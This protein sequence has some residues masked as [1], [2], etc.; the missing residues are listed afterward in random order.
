[1]RLTSDW[2]SSCTECL[3]DAAADLV[4]VAFL[5]T[6][7]VVDFVA[8]LAVAPVVVFVD[9]L[10][11]VSVLVASAGAGV[12]AGDVALDARTVFSARATFVAGLALDKM[13]SKGFEAIV[14]RDRVTI[15]V[16][17]AWDEITSRASWR[18]SCATEELGWYCR[19]LFLNEG[20]SAKRIFSRMRATITF[21]AKRSIKASIMSVE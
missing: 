11:A 12:S 2:G 4:L 9:L 7:S 16:Y 18:K 5:V 14:L 8:F 15:K 21:S 3:S 1:M 10:A 19:M 20:A 6:A 13:S 17:L